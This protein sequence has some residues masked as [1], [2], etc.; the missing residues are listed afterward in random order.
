MMGSGNMIC[1]PSLPVFRE[2]CSHSG[3]HAYLRSWAVRVADWA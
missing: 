3:T 1:K 2:S